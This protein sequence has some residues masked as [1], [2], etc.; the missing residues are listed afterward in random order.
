MRYYESDLYKKELQ[1]IWESSDFGKVLQDRTLV[2][3]GARGLIGSELIDAVMSA[4]DCHGLN[5]KMYGVVRNREAARERF[6]RY[7]DT[8]YFRLIQ[9]DINRDDI[10]ID[11]EIDFFIHGA[12]NTHPVYYARRPIETIRTNTVGTDR[13]LQF[14]ADH[15]CRRFLFLS[16]VEVY[17]ENR[18]D[19]DS[20]PETYLG[21]IDSNT[22]RA[23]YPEGKRLGETLCQAYMAELGLDCVLPRISRS[24]GPGLLK[25]DSKA[26]SQFIGKAL[27]REDIVLKS[28]G[29]QLYSYIYVADVVSALL[30][31]LAH[32]KKG[33]AYNLSGAKSDITLR[34]LA[35]YLAGLAGTKVTFEIPEETEAAGYSKATKAV[36]DTAKITALGWRSRYPIREGIKRTLELQR[37]H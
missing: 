14:A 15:H 1:E 28:R 21:Y 9:A 27:G 11:G 7:E 3:T 10:R 6:G 8:G 23:G 20:F 19:A 5:C 34:E 16:S 35:Q 26:L 12:S 32:G 18:G 29:D 31:L 24:Y 13:A 37:I 17:G 30:F 36:L 33:E 25:E 4:N 22:L 2:I